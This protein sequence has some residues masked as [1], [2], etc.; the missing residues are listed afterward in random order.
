MKRTR[1]PLAALVS[2]A[3]LSACGLAPEEKFAEA[4]ASYSSNDYAAAKIYLVSALK[5]MPGDGATLTLLARTQIAMGDGEGALASLDQIAASDRSGPAY[6]LLK[7]EAEMLRGQFEN[8][9]TAIGKP[10]SAEAARIA[11]LSHIGLGDVAAARASI[12]AGEDLPGDKAGVLAALAQIELG[13]GRVQSAIQTAQRAI[14]A[15]PENIDA[16]LISARAH[17]AANDLPATLATYEKAAKLYPQ[18]FAAELGRVSALGD[19]GRFEDTRDGLQRLSTMAPKSID[20][21]HLKARLA[22]EEKRW[23]DARVLLQGH[24]AEMR[25]SA[26]MQATYATA[27]L[28]VGQV[29]QARAWLAPL[30]EDYPTLREPRTLLAEAEL[31]AGN[32]KAA[33]QTIRALAERPD[34]RPQE[35]ALATKAARASG[36][37]SA[38]RFAQREK[39]STPE[40]IGGELAKADTALR[41]RQWHKAEESY[42]AINARMATP[43]AMVLNNLAFAKSQM[44]KNDDA[45]RIALRAVE[46]APDHP[47]VLDTAGWILFETGEDRARG[48][49]MLEQAARLDPENSGVARRLATA[50]RN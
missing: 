45:I 20:V 40:W 35:L 17:Q 44:G 30:V 32:A 31:A 19:M 48:V 49:D 50:R 11:A 29:A 39:L 13:K 16:L 3:L 37:A 5:D 4:A 25:D 46:I 34:A 21:I 1:K 9:L 41:N 23:D 36:N 33:L 26:S 15:G 27:L 2:L 42:E 12:A 18:N 6:D 47:A 22:L 38:K 7:A 28:R 8:A 14:R 24:E 43:N 10:V